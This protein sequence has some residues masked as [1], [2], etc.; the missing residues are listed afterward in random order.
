M[1]TS[2]KDDTITNDQKDLIL[3]ALEASS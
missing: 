3:N 1:D 2:I